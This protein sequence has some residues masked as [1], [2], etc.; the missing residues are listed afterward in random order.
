MGRAWARPIDVDVWWCRGAEP[1]SGDGVAE[2]SG[3]V[4]R[5]R[6]AIGWRRTG[7]NGG[8]RR[9]VGRVPGIV[10]ADHGAVALAGHQRPAE[11]RVEV[12]VVPAHTV[13]LVEAGV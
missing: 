11:A 5:G 10:G 8:C 3:L 13:E 6:P 9:R 1:A 12:V 2:Q 7:R 4:A